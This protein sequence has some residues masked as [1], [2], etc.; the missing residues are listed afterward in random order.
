MAPAPS[1]ELVAVVEALRCEQ[2][3]PGQ[4]MHLK[5]G[6]DP[7]GRPVDVMHVHGYVPGKR[8]R[9]L[10]RALWAGLGE[11]GDPPAILGRLGPG[12]RSEALA[13]T[14]LLLLH[15]LVEAARARST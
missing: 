15:P 11:H 4:P 5:R 3:A 10:Q 13:I 1:A 6:T 14:Q 12:A 7:D 2:H 9:R 8:S